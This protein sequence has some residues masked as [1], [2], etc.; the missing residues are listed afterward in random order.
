MKYL[1]LLTLLLG[2][3]C[4]QQKTWRYAG[5]FKLHNNYRVK[6]HAPRLKWNNTLQVSAQRWADNCK[7][8]HQEQCNVGENLY[9]VFGTSTRSQ[10]LNNAAKEWY[11]ENKFYDYKRTGFSP[12]TGHF[13]QMVWVNTKSFGCGT[14]FC[15]Q[16]HMRIV[17]CNYYPPG[18]V[19]NEFRKNVLE[20]KF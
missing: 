13:T 2:C 5:I 4:A 10:S 6:H 7:F 20:P 3:V 1:L 16:N 8:A 15:P 19:L 9:A 14:K 12:L 17:V 18:N 11:K